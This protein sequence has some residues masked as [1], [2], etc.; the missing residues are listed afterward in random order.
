VKAADESQADAGDKANDLLRV[1]GSELRCR[2]VGE[3][4]NLGF[5]QRG[6]IEYAL[7]GGPEGEGGQIYTDSIDNAAGVNLSDHEVNIKILLD[8]VVRERGLSEDERNELLVEMTDSVADQVLY[9]SYTQTQAISL[10]LEQA[11][12]MIDV[13]ARLIRRLEQ[14]AGLD[15]EL[16]YLPS[17]EVVSD[18]KAAHQGLAAPELAIVM[19]YCKIHLYGR[20]LHSD[21]PEDEYLSHD[22]ERY[23]PAP[24]PD[25]YGEKMRDHRLRREIIATVVANQLVDRAGTTFAFRL[26][27]ESGASPGSLARAYATAREVFEMRS[28]WAAV[29]GLDNKVDAQLQRKMLIEGRKL[30][31]RAARWLVHENPGGLR[32]EEQVRRFEPGAKLLRAAIPAVLE[33][34]ERSA[35]TAKVDELTGAGVPRELAT[36]VAAFPSLPPLFDIVAV[37]ESTGRDLEDVMHTYFQLAYHLDLGW[38]RDRIYDLP[39]ANRWQALSRAALRDDFFATHRELTREVLEAA[40]DGADPEQAIEAW[41]SERTPAVERTLSTLADIRASRTYDT[42]TLPVALREVRTLIRGGEGEPSGD[43]RG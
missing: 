32:I 13:H 33:E 20:L 31:E 26:G 40:T 42:T 37:A 16:E 14:V 17:D 43:R 28:F 8:S 15:R 25:R 38:L 35:F 10:A 34:E 3:G 18:R 23:F 7:K 30:V 19:A 41:I 22:L 1:D 6:R 2:V 29:E 39:R 36:Q 12:P 9:A 11:A 27:E 21:L 24:L 4:G 5:T